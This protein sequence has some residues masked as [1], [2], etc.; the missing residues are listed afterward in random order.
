MGEQLEH[1]AHARAAL[2]QMHPMAGP[3]DGKGRRHPRRTRPDHH[4][5]GPHGHHRISGAFAVAQESEIHPD[6]IAR[7][8]RRPDRISPVDP[9]AP[10]AD[11][12]QA[13]TGSVAAAGRR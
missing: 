13:D 6:Q 5:F 8:G 9:G 11:V 4:A 12:D 10:L 2:H 3:C 7:L 1:P